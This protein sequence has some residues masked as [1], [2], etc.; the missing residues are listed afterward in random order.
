MAHCAA[1]A[2]KGDCCSYFSRQV[3]FSSDD[4]THWIWQSNRHKTSTERPIHLDRNAR[5]SRKVLYVKCPTNKSKKI[6][7]LGA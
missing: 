4:V 6:F 2:Q 7:V 1:V 3:Q 5:L